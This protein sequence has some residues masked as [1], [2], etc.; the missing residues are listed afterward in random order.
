MF[1]GDKPVT[2]S[3]TASGDLRYEVEPTPGNILQAG[4]FG[5]WANKNAQE[6]IDQGRKPLS[7]KQTEEFVELD[8]PI[9]QYWDI[10]DHLNRIDRSDSKTKTAEKIDYINSLG[11]SIEQQ[12]VLVNNLLDRKEPVDMTDYDK[13]GSWAEFDFYIKNPEKHAFLKDNDIPYRLYSYDKDAYNWAFENQSKYAVS[14]AFLVPY[15]QY[16]AYRQNINAI[17]S[18]K[19]SSGNT[20]SGS[21]KHLRIKYINSLPI[22]NLEKA[23]LIKQYYPS[24]TAN[25]QLIADYLNVSYG[26]TAA[27]RYRILYELGLQQLWKGGS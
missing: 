20:V 11:L 15:T 13:F 1:L 4:L 25:D 22:T 3:Y 16:Y 18:L 21:Q 5:Q 23:L 10:R 8:I 12:N 7:E 26:L 17:Q 6:Y 14:K 2:G 24:E 27:E 9:Q 19:D